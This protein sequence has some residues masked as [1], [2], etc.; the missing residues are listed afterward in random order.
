MWSVG[1]RVF[2]TTLEDCMGARTLTL[3]GSIC[4]AFGEACRPSL[5]GPLAHEANVRVSQLAPWN[6]DTEYNAPYKGGPR[7]IL[8][9]QAT[10]GETTTAILTDTARRVVAILVE[11]RNDEGMPDSVASHLRQRFVSANGDPQWR[12]ETEPYSF[13]VGWALPGYYLGLVQDRPKQRIWIEKTTYQL[14]CP[15]H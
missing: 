10:H 15:M 5:S 2:H 4:I 13:A 8:N 9:C 14:T 7:P 11:L 12:C 1:D 6:C 3:L